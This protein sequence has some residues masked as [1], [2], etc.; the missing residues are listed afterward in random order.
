MMEECK[1]IYNEK[2]HNFY[3]SECG[4]ILHKT[5]EHCPICKKNITNKEDMNI[6]VI[7][8]DDNI[9]ECH[10]QPLWLPMLIPL[11]IA[12]CLLTGIMTYSLTGES[13]FVAYTQEE[14][15]AQDSK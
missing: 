2:D 12:I 8:D 5:N 7:L 11:L 14:I 9:K 3:C 10:E 1:A 15:N 6:Y 4:H 13:P